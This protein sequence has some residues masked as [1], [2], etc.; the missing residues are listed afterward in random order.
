MGTQNQGY[1]IYGKKNENKSQ[2]QGACVAQMIKHLTL[3]FSSGHE[4]MV[5]VFKPPVRLRVW[6]LLRI[7]CLSFSLSVLP[8]LLHSPSL[9]QNE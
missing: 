9:P 8:S 2:R 3:G 5:R 6:R 4:L 1:D 7:L